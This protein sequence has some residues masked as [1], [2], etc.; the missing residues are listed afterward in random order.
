MAYRKTMTKKSYGK[1]KNVIANLVSKVNKI[2]KQYKPELKMLD[3]ALSAQSISYTGHSVCVSN[4][5]GGDGAN[6]RDGFQVTAKSVNLKCHVNWN[7]SASATGYITFYIIQDLQQIPDSVPAFTDVF[8]SGAGPLGVLNR[9][10]I[11]RFKV[12]AK[13][14]V[15]QDGQRTNFVDIYR[16]LN[17]S[18]RYNGMG[19]VDYHKNGIYFLAASDRLT[20]LPAITWNCRL[21]YT[22]N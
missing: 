12:L 14:T 13:K 15:T 18:L 4:I 17:V 10:S 7:S 8:S 5:T 2:Q 21:T 20:L 22:D 3:T 9:E 11:G 6:Q 1:K 16:K 19:S